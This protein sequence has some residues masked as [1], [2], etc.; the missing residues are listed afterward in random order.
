MR[1]KHSVQRSIFDYYAEHDIGLE[2]KP[3]SAW[4][5][6]ECPILKG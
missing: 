4:L 5:D 3:M 2:L 1:E 6:L